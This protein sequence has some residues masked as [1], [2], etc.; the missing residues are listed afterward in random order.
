MSHLVVLLLATAAW[1]A[2]VFAAG[3]Q[4][5]VR[6]EAGSVSPFPVIPVFPLTAWGLA[7]MFQELSL[8]MG[9]TVIGVVHAILL[10]GFL[11]SIAKSAFRIRRAGKA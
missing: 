10:M 6:G 7:Y 2:W 3:L 8:P 9:A 5:R 11:V 4:K 1:L